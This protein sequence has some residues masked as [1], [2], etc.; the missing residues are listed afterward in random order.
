MGGES[1]ALQISLAAAFWT[2]WSL[3]SRLLGKPYKSPAA[4]GKKAWWKKTFK[5]EQSRTAQAAYFCQPA[6]VASWET[7]CPAVWRNGD[8]VL[9]GLLDDS[10]QDAVVI[11]SHRPFVMGTP[12]KREVWSATSCGG[13]GCPIEKC[14][15][16][17]LKRTDPRS[18]WC[19]FSSRCQP[20]CAVI[21]WW[22]LIKAPLLSREWATCERAVEVARQ[23]HSVIH[24]GESTQHQ[25]SPSCQFQTF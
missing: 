13:T 9:M 19:S 24:G 4:P 18:V 1:P 3:C 15:A 20:E 7:C 17:P 14:A 23:L 12:G 8:L 21:S 22:R 5:R 2:R 11:L 10:F 25:I 16:A 6:K